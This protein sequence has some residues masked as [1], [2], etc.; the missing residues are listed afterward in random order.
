MDLSAPTTLPVE[1]VVENYGG[2]DI[3]FLWTGQEK[4]ILPREVRK[5]KGRIP[6]IAKP[7][8]YEMYMSGACDRDWHIGRVIQL[9]EQA[10]IEP[11]LIKIPEAGNPY[12]ADGHHRLLSRA[13]RGDA[14]VKVRYERVSAT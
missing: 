10:E 9:A 11:L 7:Y 13:V 1:A 12:L 14:F 5:M 2:P 6:P 8:T 3:L 4:A